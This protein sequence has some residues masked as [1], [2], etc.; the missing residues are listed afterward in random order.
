M[1]KKD[2]EKIESIIDSNIVRYESELKNGIIK[3]NLIYK[4]SL[5]IK[6]Y[7]NNKIVNHSNEPE[8]HRKT[9]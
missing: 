4:M 2:I 9:I 5:E 1:I 3:E 6:E 8:K 7:I